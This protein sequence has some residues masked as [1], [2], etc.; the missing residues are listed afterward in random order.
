[1]S[2]VY[3]VYLSTSGARNI[4]TAKKFKWLK[5]GTVQEKLSKYFS[6]S[7]ICGSFRKEISQAWSLRIVRTVCL[8]CSMYQGNTREIS[9][10]M[11]NVC[12]NVIEIYIYICNCERISYSNVFFQYFEMFSFKSYFAWICSFCMDVCMFFFHLNVIF[13]INQGVP[14]PPLYF[15]PLLC[16]ATFTW[17]PLT[18]SCLQN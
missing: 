8:K 5:K 17:H 9:K 3:L 6:I 18:N 14:Q 16:W 1:M 15:E 7:T 2:L 4:L 13:K 11:L 12:L 10:C